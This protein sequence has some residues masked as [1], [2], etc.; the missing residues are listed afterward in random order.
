MYARG[1]H[2]LLPFKA[3]GVT[4]IFICFDGDDAGR[5]AAPEI[6]ARLESY[7]FTVELIPME[8]DSDPGGMDQDDVDGLKAYAAEKSTC[9]N[10]FN[11]V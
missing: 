2:K 1:K 8:D 10:P 6:Q 9:V 5:K 4:H 11:K 3:Q 7:G